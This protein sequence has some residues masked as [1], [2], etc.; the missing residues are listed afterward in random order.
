[1][2]YI[3]ERKY[4]II[5]SKYILSNFGEL[6]NNTFDGGEQLFLDKNNRHIFIDL[7]NETFECYGINVILDACKFCNTNY[8]LKPDTDMSLFYKKP[9]VLNKIL[10]CNDFSEKCYVDYNNKIILFGD[11]SA[12]G[13]CYQF[14]KDTYCIYSNNNVKLI[15]IKVED[16]ILNYINTH[17]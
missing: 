5:E 4:P 2:F 3:K 6:V 10:V 11:I 12:L 14:F 9:S 15:F 13:D 1:M 17:S 7:N 16:Q 8:S